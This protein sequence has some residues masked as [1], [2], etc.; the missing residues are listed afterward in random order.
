MPIPRTRGA[1]RCWGQSWCPEPAR[2]LLN[3]RAEGSP[4]MEVSFSFFVLL[5]IYV[6]L[7]VNV[8]VAEYEPV[9]YLGSFV[10]VQLTVA[11][12]PVKRDRE[13]WLNVAMLVDAAVEAVAFTGVAVPP[14]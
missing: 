12:F 11:E 9:L 13:S 4:T 8:T 6:A 10:N 14:F 5:L 3:P 7:I 1:E 2:V